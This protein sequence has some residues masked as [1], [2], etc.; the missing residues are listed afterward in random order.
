M[1]RSLLYMERLVTETR[2]LR[3]YCRSCD[4]CDLTCCSCLGSYYFPPISWGNADVN[5]RESGKTVFF[6]E[7]EKDWRCRY[8]GSSFVLL[9]VASALCWSRKIQDIAF[10]VLLGW[11][12]KVATT[13]LRSTTYTGKRV[14]ITGWI[15]HQDV[16]DLNK[17]PEWE[18]SD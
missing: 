18:G 8:W 16:G 4:S 17:G 3:G 15:F 6:L 1:V 14:W 13:V 12:G 10:T 11:Q 7:A 2:L 5:L 9:K